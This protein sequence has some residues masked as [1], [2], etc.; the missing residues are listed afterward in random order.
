[1]IPAQNREIMRNE[2]TREKEEEEDGEIMTREKL[3]K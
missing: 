3:C 1:M 2:E